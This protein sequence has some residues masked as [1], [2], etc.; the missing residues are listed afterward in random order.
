ML[1]ELP[2]F[3]SNEECDKLIKRIDES[4][5]RS[6]VAGAGKDKSQV[7]SSRTSSTS[8]LGKEELSVIIQKR[9]S[10]ELGT[11][12]IRGEDL[13][14]QKYEPGQYF[15][16]HN[17]FFEGDSY[18]NHCLHSGNRTHTFMIY[19][20]DDFEG[21]GTN[22][23]NLNTTIKPEKG[24]AVW[25]YDM[26]DGELQR[27]T[28]HEGMDVVSGQKYIVTSW[29]REKPWN[30]VLDTQL[31]TVHHRTELPGKSFSKWEDLPKIDP[32]GFRVVKVPDEAWSIIQE[33][34]SDVKNARVEEKFE[35]KESI[36][37][38]EGITSY[39]MDINVFQEKRQIVHN[40]LLPMHE[41]FAKEAIEPTFIYG[42]RS[43]MRGAALQFHRDRI[44][45]HHISSIIVVDKDLACGCAHKPESDDWALDVQSHDGSWHQVT[46]NVGEMI[47]YESATCQHGRNTIFEGTSFNNMFVHYKL[48]DWTYVGN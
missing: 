39:I 46:A 6:S 41:E 38:G 27:D 8:D 42:I 44:A 2:N 22:F 25:W 7:D 33:M 48:K 43:Y 9:I 31:S 45:T 29:W 21:G 4:N 14:G 30:N 18:T 28:L 40:M 34:Y 1:I 12:I 36:I 17:D 23:P 13:Q 3:L 11:D 32:I 26:K 37:P 10:E 16:P 24:K 19:L 5:T 15:R 20:N 35:G 47:L